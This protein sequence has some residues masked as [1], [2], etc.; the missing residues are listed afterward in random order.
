MTSNAVFPSDAADPIVHKIIG[1][2]YGRSIFEEGGRWKETPLLEAAR[3]GD[4]AACFL[5]LEVMGSIYKKAYGNVR[6]AMNSNPSTNSFRAIVSSDI[7]R[8]LNARNVRNRNALHC[9]VAGSNLAIA[10]LLLRCDK[11]GILMNAVDMRGETPVHAAVRAGNVEMLRL[12]LTADTGAPTRSHQSGGE[13][14]H[15]PKVNTQTILNTQNKAGETP[16]HLASERGSTPLY[17]RNFSSLEDLLEM[18]TYPAASSSWGCVATNIMVTSPCNSAK[19]IPSASS[20]GERRQ[21]MVELLLRNGSSIHC[22]DTTGVTPLHRAASEGQLEVVRLL[23]DSGANA[24][25][26]DSAGRTPLDAARMCG[27]KTTARLVEYLL[28]NRQK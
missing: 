25:L 28:N 9:A 8:I 12:L 23:I 5:L 17:N 21:T 26:K 7:S 20:R 4:E 3:T 14:L 6:V 10:R 16:L 19:W 15:D 22:K 27:H 18:K 13:S 24:E 11:F 2:W 1:F